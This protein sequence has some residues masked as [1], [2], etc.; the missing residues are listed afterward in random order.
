MLYLVIV[1]SCVDLILAMLLYSRN[2]LTWRLSAFEL[3]LVSMNILTALAA[4]YC[5]TSC[6]KL[7]YCKSLWI[8][9]S[10]NCPKCKY[11]WIK[12]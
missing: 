4:I 8:K 10:D 7:I 2:G 3:A 9:A 5:F 1:L 6:D 12:L 11:K